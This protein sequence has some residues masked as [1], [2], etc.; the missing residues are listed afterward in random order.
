M[1]HRDALLQRGVNP[2]T[3]IIQLSK[4]KSVTVRQVRHG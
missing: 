4:G 1:T 2:S 3:S